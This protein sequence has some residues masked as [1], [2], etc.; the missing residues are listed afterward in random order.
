MEGATEWSRCFQDQTGIPA[1]QCSGSTTGLG[2]EKHR[3]AGGLHFLYH[4]THHLD[5]YE[6]EGFQ[7]DMGCGAGQ[8]AYA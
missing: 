1:G 8:E 6:K 5:G 2:G 4:L 7:H 3:V